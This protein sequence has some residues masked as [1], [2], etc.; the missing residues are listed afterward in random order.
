MFDEELF[1]ER[2]AVMEFDA[3]MG[4]AEAERLAREDM[5][6]CEIR[7]CIR[8]FYPDGQ[9]MAAHLALVEKKRGKPATDKLRVDL[10]EAWKT[11]KSA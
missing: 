6:R 8:N 3:G 9:A 10:R 7:W 4:R 5:H 1:E 2:A 11:R